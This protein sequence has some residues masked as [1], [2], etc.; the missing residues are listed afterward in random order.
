M[1]TFIEET[2]KKPKTRGSFI[3]CITS[4]FLEQTSRRGWNLMF[5]LDDNLLD[6]NIN[7]IQNAEIL[8][9]VIYKF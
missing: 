6:G 2:H 1:K 4:F 7:T 5:M 9:A 3:T 8:T